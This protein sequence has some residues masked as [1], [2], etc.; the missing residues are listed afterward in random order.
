MDHTSP[1]TPWA[2]HM[3]Q[4]PMHLAYFEGTMFEAV[5]KIAGTHPNFVAFDFMGKATT[6]RELVQNIRICAKALLKRL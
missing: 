6:Y 2:A 3:G 5:E 1:K 4:V